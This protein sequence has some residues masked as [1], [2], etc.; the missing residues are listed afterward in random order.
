MKKIITASVLAMGMMATS[1]SAL[2]VGLGYAVG[3]ANSAEASGVRVPLD[4]DFGLRIE[5][6]LGFSK[7]LTTLAVGGYY[8]FMKIEEV[9]LFAGGRLGFTKSDYN[10][11]N[12]NDI[13]GMSLQGLVG[14]EYFVVPKKFSIA[15]QVGLESATGD[16]TKWNNGGDT[17]FGTTGAVI[18]HFFF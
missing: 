10:Y 16:L 6:E 3:A 4:F 13:T 14:A 18:G 2:E 5:P 1:A 9:N 7:H 15:A 8:T 17:D 11:I 12:G